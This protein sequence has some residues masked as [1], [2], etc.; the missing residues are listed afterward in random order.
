MGRLIGPAGI[1][2]KKSIPQTT[3]FDHGIKPLS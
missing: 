2:V 1:N 3:V